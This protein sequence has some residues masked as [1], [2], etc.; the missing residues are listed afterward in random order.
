MFIGLHNP[1]R[2]TA[3]QHKPMEITNF[4]F[5]PYSISRHNK[6]Y[7]KGPGRRITESTLTLTAVGTM[8]CITK[9]KFPK[10]SRMTEPHDFYY[11]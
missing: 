8:P 6:E 10:P 3:C 7:Y 2:S 4:V 5:N 9:Y 11:L 1:P